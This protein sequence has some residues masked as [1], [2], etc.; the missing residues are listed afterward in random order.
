MLR[1]VV[2]L[3]LRRACKLIIQIQD[4]ARIDFNTHG[5][6]ADLVR[7]NLYT[8]I[9]QDSL[10]QLLASIVAKLIRLSVSGG[11]KQVRS[12]GFEHRLTVILNGDLPRALVVI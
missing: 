6:D 2:S 8:M 4:K 7:I 12:L 1:F 11:F 9:Q 5:K 10:L 3:D